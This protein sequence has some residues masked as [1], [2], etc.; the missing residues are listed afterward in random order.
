MSITIGG[1]PARGL[2]WGAEQVNRA[3]LGSTEIF[4]REDCLYSVICSGMASYIY[5]GDP[6]VI[7]CNLYSRVILRVSFIPK[8]DNGKATT[9]TAALNLCQTNEGAGTAFTS[10]VAA[11]SSGPCTVEVVVDIPEDMAANSAGLLYVPR[12]KVEY[13]DGAGTFMFDSNIEIIGTLQPA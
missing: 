12:C 3:F 5:A 7:D 11:T 2:Y 9:L 1:Q 6:L 8:E 4:R 13:F 10:S